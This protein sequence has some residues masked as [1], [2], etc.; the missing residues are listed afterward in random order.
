M[1]GRGRRLWR[2]MLPRRRR[3]TGRSTA[4]HPGG[5]CAKTGGVRR[6]RSG[7]SRCAG[8]KRSDESAWPSRQISG[9]T[10]GK[11][12]GV[13]I[14]PAPFCFFRAPAWRGGSIA[15]ARTLVAPR[16]A[17]AAKEDHRRNCGNEHRPSP[18]GMTTFVSRCAKHGISQSPGI[19]R[20]EPRRVDGIG[21]KR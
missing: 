20:V 2:R 1:C 19:R 18:Q 9:A 5:G 16:T 17:G 7:Y 21:K 8:V 14:M 6:G 15:S 10:V 11:G 4:L 12:E 13:G 3:G